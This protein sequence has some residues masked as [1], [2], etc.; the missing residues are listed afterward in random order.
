MRR[1]LVIGQVKT[2]SLYDAEARKTEKAEKAAANRAKLLA[3]V[4]R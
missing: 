2:P 1:L 3:I 4:S